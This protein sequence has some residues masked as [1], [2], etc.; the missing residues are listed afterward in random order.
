MDKYKYNFFIPTIFHSINHWNF[1][2][3]F[4]CIHITNIGL[5]LLGTFPSQ[6]EVWKVF[7]TNIYSYI[8]EKVGTVDIC[9]LND[10]LNKSL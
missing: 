5:N 4:K 3:Y 2:D 10:I 7:K 8:Y 9:L 1:F 6:N